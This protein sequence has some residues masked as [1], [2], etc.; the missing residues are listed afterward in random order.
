[1]FPLL[2]I[3]W[4]V[5]P[6]DFVVPGSILV[7]G[8]ILFNRSWSSRLLLAPPPPHCPVVTEML[9][10]K[11]VKWQ[12]M[13]PLPDTGTQLVSPSDP[14]KTVVPVGI[15]D[16]FLYDIGWL[17]LVERP[18]E[19]I[20]QSI[21]GRLPRTGRKNREKIDERKNVQTTPARTYCKRNRPLP[22]YHPN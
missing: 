7:E 16:K 3:L 20:F 19:T 5:K 13:H 9:L 6:F 15:W 10:K 21:S 22:Y 11:D 18:F 4:E 1:M 2:R 12:I 17:I 14:F 8:V